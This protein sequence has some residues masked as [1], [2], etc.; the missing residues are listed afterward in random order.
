MKEAKA[1]T[2]V[3]VLLLSLAVSLDSFT[4]G[5]AYGM[6]HIRIPVRSMLVIAACSFGAV[7]L[8]MTGG[9]WLLGW[10]SPAWGKRLGAFILCFV[11]LWS[12]WNVRRAMREEQGREQLPQ[13]RPKR[14]L[15]EI[16][17]FGYVIQVLKK[18]DMADMDRSG[19]ISTAEALLLGLALS[20][21]AM[22]AAVGAVMVGFSPWLTALGIGGFSCL[23]LLLGLQAGFRLGSCKWV[24]SASLLPGMLLLLLGFSKLF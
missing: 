23:F 12:L 13:N 19:I 11:G 9:Q 4:V 22:G 21:D 15:W 20:L 10:M 18:P 6:R 1:V 7:L 17:L 5:T 2:I 14:R 3:S 24:R 8:I 16:Q